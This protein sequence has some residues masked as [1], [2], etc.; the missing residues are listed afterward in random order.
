VLLGPTVNLRRT[1]IGGR[2]F[3]CYAEDPLLTARLAVAFIQGLQG[4]GIGASIK[5]LVAN[6]VEHDRHEVSSE[7]DERTLREVSLLPF[8]RAVAEADPWT[9]M[10]AYNRVNGETATANRW[11]LTEVL[12]KGWGWPGMVVSDWGA[13]KDTVATALAGCDLE[14]P[15]PTGWMGPRLAEA[16]EAGD[17]P[18]VVLDDLARRVL[19]L[20]ERAG[21]LDDT[22]EPPERSDDDPARRA[23][24]RRAA[25]EGSVLLRNDGV[26]P[27]DR[28]SLRRVAVIGPNVAT[29]M[30]QGGGSSQVLPHGDIVG[31][32]EA[33]RAALGDAV[34]VVH[35]PGCTNHKFAAAVPSERW[36]GGRPGSGGAPTTFAVAARVDD[37]PVLVE[38]F[39]GLDLDGDPARTWRADGI[40]TTFFGRV[41]GLAD[42]SRFSGRFTGSFVPAVTGAHVLGVSAVGRS[43]LFL[44][45]VEVLDAWTDPQPGDTFFAN[46]SVEVRA[47]V[48][49]VEGKT[50]EIVVELA[51]DP[52]ATVQGVRLGIDPPEPAGLIDRAADAAA[53]ADVAVVIVGTTAE[54]ETE[55]NDRRDIDLPGRQ[56]ELIEAVAAANPRTVVVVNAGSPVEMGWVEQVGAALQV[57]FG[58]QEMGPALAAMLLGDTEPGGRL[59]HTIPMRLE[60][61]PAFSSYPGTDGKLVYEE[62]LLAGHRWYDAEGIEPRFPFG[63]GL[64]YTTFEWEG[65]TVSVGQASAASPGVVVTVPVTNTGD[66]AGAEVVQLYV[67][68]PH[69]ADRP[70]RELKTFAKVT[71][72]PG[73][74]ADVVL[75]LD[76]VAF[77]TWDVHAAAWVVHPGTYELAV[78][79]SSRDLRSSVT[80]ELEA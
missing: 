17:V 38:L 49:L 35:E 5:H 67:R 2:N 72:A 9:V 6:D 48:D 3:E 33:L 60:D 57:W 15:G 23:L 44:D 11:L 26:L 37:G 8:E 40:T 51:T 70:D 58:G 19:H 45:G 25:T 64:S 10:A 75:D 71:L 13:V 55:G 68:P 46:G 52:S 42:Q 34:E 24:A 65:A 32:L 7:V 36:A 53:D 76:A 54:W 4:N 14:M 27:L 74:T 78:G 22:D 21:R 41:R 30:V 1:P 16:V 29:F 69:G 59:P 79:A 20:A 66:R 61:H 39:D 18:E 73:E 63:H 62:G 56:A 80:V 12:K 47:D 77:R 28:G 50:V 31:P 43:R